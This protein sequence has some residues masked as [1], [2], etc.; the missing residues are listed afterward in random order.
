MTSEHSPELHVETGT[1]L[2]FT[3]KPMHE[4]AVGGPQ[5]RNFQVEKVFGRV[6]TEM[7]F[8]G[9]LFVKFNENCAGLG[10]NCGE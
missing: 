5:A 2:Y 3:H 7:V 4:S 6:I 10:L 1:R 9:L 8:K